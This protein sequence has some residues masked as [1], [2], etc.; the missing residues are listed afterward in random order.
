MCKK[1]EI[2]FVIFVIIGITKKYTTK[3]EKVIKI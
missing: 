2:A 3:I 1:N